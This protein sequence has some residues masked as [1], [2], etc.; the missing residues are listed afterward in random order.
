MALIDLIKRPTKSAADIRAKIEAVRAEDPAARKPALLAERKQALLEGRDKDAD[1]IV[2]QL[3]GIDNDVERKEHA[4]ELLARELAQKEAEEHAAEVQK[5]VKAAK[6]ATRK[7]GDI[8]ARYERGADDVLAAMA[9]LEEAENI[10]AAANALLPPSEQLPTVEFAHRGLPGEPCEEV[11]RRVV[12]HAWF[13]LDTGAALSAKQVEVIEKVDA[14]HGHLWVINTNP[15]GTDLAG[16]LPEITQTH[17]ND[18]DRADHPRRKVAVVRRQVVEVE[19]LD[20][21]S[22]FNPVALRYS[23]SL[24]TV[25]S[26]GDPRPARE[27]RTFRHV[28]DIEPVA[29]VEA[30]E[31]A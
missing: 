4:L 5:A 14:N 19:Y 17:G 24:P 20:A 10:V 26:V 29:A 7:A 21:R 1:R 18:P 30:S 12:D 11:G 16:A 2:D 28:A 25:L 31:A 9:E 6:Q 23:V 8:F 3:R 27:R 22:A 15:T 13:R